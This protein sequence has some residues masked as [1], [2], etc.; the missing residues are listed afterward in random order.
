M[1]HLL[2]ILSLLFIVGAEA[3]RGDI[4]TIHEVE[5]GFMAGLTNSYHRA[6]RWVGLKNEGLLKTTEVDVLLDSNSGE[7]K[8]RLVQCQKDILAGKTDIEGKM[9]CADIFRNTINRF[10]KSYNGS[11]ADTVVKSALKV[12]KNETKGYTVER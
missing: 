6:D 3:Y 9:P 7:Y 8:I 1:K 12:L 11:V 4:K 5:D 10:L 2:L